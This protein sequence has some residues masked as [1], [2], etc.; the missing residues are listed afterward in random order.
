MNQVILNEP[1][2]R[3]IDDLDLPIFEWKLDRLTLFYAPGYLAAADPRRTEE[4]RG[5][6][7]G[8]LPF[9]D[10][11]TA[12]YLINE[13]VSAQQE[14]RM[15]H[16]PA[17]YHP[18]CLTLYSSLDCNLDC[19]Y[20]FAKKSHENPQQLETDFILSSA[21]LVLEN[22]REKSMPFTAV[23]Q[24]GGEP[25]MDPRLPE[26][27]TELKGMSKSEAVPFQSYIAT[28][29]VMDEKKARWIAENIDRIGLSVDGPP[30]IQ[31]K[32]RPLRSGGNTSSIVERTAE[33]FRSIQG[34]LAIRGTV[35]PQNFSRIPE[36]IRYCEEV[37]HA[38]QIR[39]EPVYLHAQEKKSTGDGSVCTK[40]WY[41][42]NRPLYTSGS[43]VREIHGRY[44]QIFR[45][46][47]HLVPSAGYS[48]CF[49]VASQKEAAEKKLDDIRDDALFTEL[50]REDPA[51]M[52]CFN[53]FHCSRG[54][55]EVCPVMT[56]ELSD[57][58]SFRCRLNRSAAAAE[59]LDLAERLLREPALQYGYAGLKLREV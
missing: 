37:L 5:T 3:Q 26:L 34:K 18:T 43:R 2:F 14:W 20:C 1:G 16:D 13:A 30:D 6:L 55:P 22:C 28:N 58:G 4:I 36:I 27:L 39:L 44:C 25:S 33:I 7:S 53:R 23:F 8:D 11:L 38:D 45:Q 56:P 52:R 46:V 42:Q 15:I 10:N 17:D 29:G 54:C 24:G 50:A 40:F 59:L 32:Q 51:C 41:T 47:L 12:H 35:L 49:A 19:I 21:K 31:N 57:A 9:G 48:A